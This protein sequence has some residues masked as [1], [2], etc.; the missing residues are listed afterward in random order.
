VPIDADSGYRLAGL[1]VGES[2]VVSRWPIDESQTVDLVF[3]RIDVW[4][5]DARIFTVGASG[6]LTEHPRPA[7]GHF[8]GRGVI[9]PRLAVVVAIGIDGRI[10]RMISFGV[11]DTLEYRRGRR[12]V[13]G[14][15]MLELVQTEGLQG[16]ASPRWT[17]GQEELPT[18]FP[19]VVPQQPG[20]H[21]MSLGS[22]HTATVAVDTDNEFM[23]LKFGNNTTNATA[24][25]ADLFA[26]I[27]V[28]YERDLNVRL[29][30]GTTFLRVAA[31]P[32]TQTTSGSATG[33]QLN[34][35][36]NYWAVNQGG[37]TR[38][39]AAMLSGKQPTNN[40]ASGIAW[41]NGLCST[42]LG[43]SFSQVFKIDYLAGDA[44]VVGHEIGH[45]FGSPH[46]HCYS[47]P[48]DT[49]YS[50]EGGCYSGSTTCPA[51]A[52][53]NGVPNVKGT[54]MSYC[55]ILGGCS[56]SMVFHPTVEAYLDP[57]MTSKIGVCLMP[58]ATNYTLTVARSGAGSGTVNSSPAGISCGGDCSEPYSSGT[59]VTL[60][61]TPDGS[62]AFAGW[63]GACSG[64]SSCQATMSAARSV[65]AWFSSTTGCATTVTGQAFTA[66]Q[67]YQSCY[68]IV[69][70]PNVSTTTAA[71]HLTLRAANRVVLRNG[72]WIGDDARLTIALDP[73]LAGT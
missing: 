46:T 44:S 61:A 32:Y 16:D 63:S 64:S 15:E 12:T 43:Y 27:N 54:I 65:T 21:A 36:S 73:S 41:L 14:E 35:F 52:T 39:L 58:L 10:D 17:C 55:H 2:I 18:A 57:I 6:A 28:M 13:T 66:S 3:T 33:A 71:G 24:Y 34:E 11:D 62:S 4:D 30:V 38:A 48:I 49:C 25:I 67:L 23:S 68:S 37:V 56:A 51:A 1:E 45:N 26:A 20:V 5:P 47:P 59:V 70:G 19:D 31:D 29:L 69:A 22:L 60:T 8:V 40:S 42:S 9:D 53:V 50:G 72:F 7:R